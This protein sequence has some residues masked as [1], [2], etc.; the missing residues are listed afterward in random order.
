[1]FPFPVYA[2]QFEVYPQSGEAFESL[3][4]LLNALTRVDFGL[5]VANPSVNQGQ[6][7]SDFDLRLEE[8]LCDHGAVAST[9]RPPPSVPQELDFAITF[10]GSTVAVEIEKANREKILRDFLKCHMYLQVGADLALVVLPRNYPHTT[11]VWD[12]F[13]FG[14]QRLAECR[15]FGFGTPDKLDRILLLGFVQYDSRTDERLS[16]STRVRMRSE[17]SNR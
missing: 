9:F 17:A 7:A 13:S 1:M 6:M 10:A 16:V 12:L 4:P 5:S 3:S 8:A 14:V 2:A 15:T 11:S